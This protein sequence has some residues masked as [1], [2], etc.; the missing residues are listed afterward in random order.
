MARNFHLVMSLGPK[1]SGDRFYDSRKGR[2]G[3]GVWVHPKVAKSKAV[4]GLSFGNTLDGTG[5]AVSVL[6]FTNELR[7]QASHLVG[8]PLLAVKHISPVW[9]SGCQPRAM[10]IASSLMVGVA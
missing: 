6:V 8:P 10:T 7:K 3:G 1:F 9:T 5:W 4:S 2:T